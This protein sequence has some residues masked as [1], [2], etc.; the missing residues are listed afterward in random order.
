MGRPCEKRLLPIFPWVPD[1]I[2]TIY[3]NPQYCQPLIPKWEVG[4][5]ECPLGDALPGNQCPGLRCAILVCVF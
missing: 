5:S 1:V 3:T 2:N 4:T